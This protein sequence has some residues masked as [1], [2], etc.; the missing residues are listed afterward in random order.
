MHFHFKQWMDIYRHMGHLVVPIQSILF[1]KV[2]CRNS[3]TFLNEIYNIYATLENPPQSLPTDSLLPELLPSHPN[4]V[5][6]STTRP[7]IANKDNP[8]D[9][10]HDS[11]VIQT[12][13]QHG[14]LISSNGPHTLAFV[15][16]ILRWMDTL[17]SFHTKHL[18]YMLTIYTILLYLIK[19]DQLDTSL[20][21]GE[22]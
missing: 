1:C 10:S 13:L 22:R 7:L 5:I 2:N 19:K 4:D 3:S 6:P 8:C 14:P 18:V 12:L 17:E 16:L 11:R 9:V 20:Y 15:S 21:I